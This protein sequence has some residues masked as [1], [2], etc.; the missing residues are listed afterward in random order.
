[1]GTLLT[2]FV[3]PSFYSVFVRKVK[4]EGSEEEAIEERIAA[5]PLGE[6]LP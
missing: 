6:Q 1:V 2:L 4:I 5:R 3:V